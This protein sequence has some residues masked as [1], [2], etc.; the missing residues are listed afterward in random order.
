MILKRDGRGPRSYRLVSTA[1]LS[2]FV[3]ELNE[4]GAAGFRLVPS[5][6]KGTSAVLEQQPDGA[7]FTYSTIE[8]V[9]AN[10]IGA[11]AD[12]RKRGLARVGMLSLDGGLS[13]N[14]KPAF[15]L[16]G[17]EGAAPPSPSG[18]SE[19]RILTTSRTA[20]LEKEIVQA[21]AEGFDAVAAGYMI[22][23]MERVASVAAPPSDYRVI[24]MRRVATAGRELQE[25]GAE[26]FRIRVV[27]DHS[28]EGVFVLHRASGSSERFDYHIA[29]LKPKTANEQLVQAEGAGFRIA[30]L[31]NDLVVLEHALTR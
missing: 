27:P 25:A 23:L 17:I 5:S 18:E 24:A 9:G 6:V 26:G 14:Q 4:A 20:T 7:R 31:F 12:A 10:S 16:E 21:A 28:Q 2:S 15:L 3:K 1:R 13:F 11:R 8:G 30:V 22:V 29:R 19:Y